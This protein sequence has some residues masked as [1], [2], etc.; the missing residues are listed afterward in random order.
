MTTI[1][2][3]YVRAPDGIPVEVA[4]AEAKTGGLEWSGKDEMFKSILVSDRKWSVLDNQP[5]DEDNLE[6]V[7]KL[8]EIFAGDYQWAELVTLSAGKAKFKQGSGNW[9]HKGR[10]GKRGGSLGKLTIDFKP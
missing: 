1:V 10:P 2:K 5:F 6:H 9:R 7:M 3:F 4:Q 8:P